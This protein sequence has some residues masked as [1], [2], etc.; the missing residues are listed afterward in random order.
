MSGAKQK[1]QRE[2]GSAYHRHPHIVQQRCVPRFPCQMGLPSTADRRLLSHQADP[3]ISS[4]G[5][6]F[7]PPKCVYHID[8]DV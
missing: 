6:R 4:L 1:K 8:G 5:Y 7:D 2:E 3:P